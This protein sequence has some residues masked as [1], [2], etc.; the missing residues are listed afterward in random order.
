M[1]RIEAD[2]VCTAIAPFFLVLLA[3]G[4][5]LLLIP[6][7]ADA[8]YPPPGRC[9]VRLPIQSLFDEFAREVTA[10]LAD[11][12]SSWCWTKG[13]GNRIVGLPVEGNQKVASRVGRC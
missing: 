10:R 3:V 5:M 8:D 12:C 2:R 9:A 1:R 7:R 4:A 11:A 6:L 13:G